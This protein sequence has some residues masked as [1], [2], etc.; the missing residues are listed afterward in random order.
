MGAEVWHCTDTLLWLLKESGETIE[1]QVRWGFTETDTLLL[2]HFFCIMLAMVWSLHCVSFCA[3][4]SVL[5]LLLPEMSNWSS[6]SAFFA[7]TALDKNCR[8]LPL[9]HSDIVFAY[10]F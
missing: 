5:T 9:S 3:G 10:Q 6:Y 8:Q 2:A 1:E 4:K 7:P